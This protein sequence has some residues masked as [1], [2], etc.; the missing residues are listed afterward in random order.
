MNDD[1][2]RDAV[3]HVQDD[4]DANA[5][6]DRYH[7]SGMFEGAPTYDGHSKILADITMQEGLQTLRRRR[8]SG[9]MDMWKNNEHCQT[10]VIIPA[11]RAGR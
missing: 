1:Q 11:Q 3:G 7:V 2:L 9:Q 5:E 10:L 8:E 6:K 4:I